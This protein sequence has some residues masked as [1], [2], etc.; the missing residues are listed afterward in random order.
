MYSMVDQSIASISDL[1]MHI[2]LGSLHLGKYGTSVVYINYEPP[3]RTI[4]Y[5]LQLAHTHTHTH[6]YFIFDGIVQYYKYTQK[7]KQI[8]QVQVP[9]TVP[10]T[11]A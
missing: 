9:I 7:D 1:R 11:V 10:A 8:M 4:Y 3:Y 5:I 6:T 2:F